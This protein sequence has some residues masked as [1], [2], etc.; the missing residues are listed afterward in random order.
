AVENS[1]RRHSIRVV[2]AVDD[3]L[4]ASFDSFID[5]VHRSG[6]ARQ[7]FGRPHIRQLGLQKALGLL[8]L[9]DAPLE[10]QLSNHWRHLT[11]IRESLNFV[12]TVR[13]SIPSLALHP[14]VSYARDSHCSH[15]A[16][17]R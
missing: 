15:P 7:F 2:I 17:V 5:T 6:Q 9:L 1:G 14:D 8:G 12:H 3:N 11:T 4:L 13:N 16:L 10:Q